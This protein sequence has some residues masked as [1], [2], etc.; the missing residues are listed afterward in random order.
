VLEIFLQAYNFD[1][2]V[3]NIRFQRTGGIHNNYFF[4]IRECANAF[5]P[6]IEEFRSPDAVVRL[7]VLCADVLSAL[8]TP[9]PAMNYV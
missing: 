7:V 5:I 8:V 6:N 4:R 1:V 9:P 2:F 3:R